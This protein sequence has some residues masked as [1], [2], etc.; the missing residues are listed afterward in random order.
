VRVR[1]R[2]IKQPRNADSAPLHSTL[3]L[4]SP[5]KGG[6]AQFCSMCGPKFCSMKITQDVPDYAAKKEEAE[7]GMAE[8][9]AKFRVAAGR[10]M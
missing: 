9:S 5:S 10:S 4:P 6:R 3:T 8:M 2:P 1:R 7:R